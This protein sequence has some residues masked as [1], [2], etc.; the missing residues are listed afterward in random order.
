MTNKQWDMAIGWSRQGDMRTQGPETGYYQEFRK[1]PAEEQARLTADYDSRYGA[2]KT[3][4]GGGYTTVKDPLGHPALQ[5]IGGG[6]GGNAQAAPAKMP[7]ATTLRTSRGGGGGGKSYK[8]GLGT[9][10]PWKEAP[11][12]Q[13]MP[14]VELHDNPFDKSYGNQLGLNQANQTPVKP[15]QSTVTTSITPAPIYTPEMTQQA[16]NQARATAAQQANPF[17]QQKQFDRPGM[18]RSAGSMGAAMPGIAE[19]ISSGNSAASALQFADAAANAQHMLAAQAAQD[20]E[21]LGLAGINMSL[22]EQRQAF[23]NAQKQQRQN[24]LLQLINGI[25]GGMSGY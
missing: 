20:Q 19:A 18:S 5:P 8:L 4:A 12:T 6:G 10:T 2:P 23:E 11:S 3:P 16:I 7:S 22:A 14:P 24:L 1:L 21:G 25:A 17:F 15:G 13:P 9:Y